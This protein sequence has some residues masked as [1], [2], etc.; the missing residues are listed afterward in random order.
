M[1]RQILG[2]PMG[3]NSESLVADLFLFCSERDFVLSLSGKVQADVIEVV[4]LPLNI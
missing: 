1:N 2:N 3:S 4:T